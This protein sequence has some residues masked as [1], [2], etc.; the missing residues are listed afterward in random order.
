M[1]KIKQKPEDFFVKEIIE[2]KSKENGRYTYFILKKKNYTTLRALQHIGNILKIPIKNFG[3]A[4][5]KDKKAVTE[6]SVSAKNISKERIEEIK[7]KDIEINFIGKG[8]KPISL[9]DLEGNYFEIIARDCSKEPKKLE[10]FKNFFGEQRFSKNNAE[11]GKAIIKKEFEK[12]AKLISENK[13]DQEDALKKHLEKRKNDFVGALRKIP[14]KILKIYV[15]AYQSLLWNRMA[16][17]TEK[18]EIPIIGFATKLDQECK[19]ILLKE[20]INQR[21][22]IIREIPELTSEGDKRKVFVNVKKLEIKKIEEKDYMLKF[23]LPKGS[24]ATEFIRQSFS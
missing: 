6:Q 17:N 14:L 15:H 8:D 9:G 22:F 13:G 21:D 18:K 24:Y 23:M 16:E 2:L 4:G 7:L 11:I 1:Y 10:S 3:F 5:T 20:G 12:A 19:K